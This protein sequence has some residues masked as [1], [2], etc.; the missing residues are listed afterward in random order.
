MGEGGKEEGGRGIEGGREVREEEV[1]EVGEGGEEGEGEG[2]EG[3][4]GGDGDVESAR[5][6][7]SLR[8]LV[9]RRAR[10]AAKKSP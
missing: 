9:E 10:M 4:G 3:E 7:M 8:I 1:E 5:A 6:M 2:G